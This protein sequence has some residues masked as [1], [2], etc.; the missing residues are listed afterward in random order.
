MVFLEQVQ[1]QDV[2]FY[3]HLEKSLK[4]TQINKARKFLENN[5]IQYDVTRKLFFCLPLQ[6]YNTRTYE[7]TRAKGTDCGFECNCQFSQKQKREGRNPA[8]SHILTL[9]LWF[10]ARNKERGW[11]RWK[12]E[13]LGNGSIEG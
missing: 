10:D 7:L 13:E 4:Q 11:G 1:V 12:Q 5:C 8:C 6:G 9:H 3:S 2:Q